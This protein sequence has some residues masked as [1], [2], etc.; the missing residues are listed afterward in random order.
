MIEAVMKEYWPGWEEPEDDGRTWIPTECPVHGDDNPSASV[1]YELNAYVCHACGYTGDYLKIIG[2]EEELTY[3][4]ALARAEEIADRRG[5]DV[6]RS[7]TG[8]PRRGVSRPKRFG[9]L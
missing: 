5:I 6:P 7:P 9:E 1:S 3:A 8:K 2:R 4:E